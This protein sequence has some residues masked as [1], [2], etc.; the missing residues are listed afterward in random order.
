MNI[1][2]VPIMGPVIGSADAA[3]ALGVRQEALEA[4]IQAGDIPGVHT[5]DGWYMS[6]AVLNSI[7]DGTVPHPLEAFSRYFNN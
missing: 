6:V 3:L 1:R 5:G 2:T 4:Y 7:A